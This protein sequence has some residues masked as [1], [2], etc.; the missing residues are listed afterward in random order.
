[1]SHF[2]QKR[3]GFNTQIVRHE[4]VRYGFD[5]GRWKLLFTS[6]SCSHTSNIYNYSFSRILNVSVFCLQKG[7]LFSS[8]KVS[9]FLE[10]GVFF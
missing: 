6:C 9:V 5:R 4:L 3:C 1:M 10:I 2:S 7:S 8:Q